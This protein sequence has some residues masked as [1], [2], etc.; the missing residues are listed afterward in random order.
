[1]A[2]VDSGSASPGDDCSVTCPFSKE[3]HV[4]RACGWLA[5]AALLLWSW[6]T[7]LTR[8][9][10]DA[11]DLSVCRTMNATVAWGVPVATLW[12]LTGIKAFDL[13]VKAGMLLL[14]AFGLRR[15][16]RA[17]IERAVSVVIVTF[18]AFILAVFVKQ[19]YAH[20]PR[21]SPSMVLSGIYSIKAFVPWSQAKELAPSTFPSDHA[22]TMLLICIIWWR[23]FGARVGV[24]LAAATF[25]V[26]L[27]RLAAGAHWLTDDLVGGVTVM[28]V[29]MSVV[30][31]TPFFFRLY[32]KIA[33]SAP[34]RGLV[35]WFRR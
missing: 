28:A 34:V 14:V 11:V 7:P 16:D 35:S 2:I 3:W 26:V 4:M 1:M 13:L 6:V 10:W 17:A 29:V 25:F 32:N 8:A 27:P 9:L 18:F 24:I 31:G 12:A 20:S 30:D 22:M 5:I 15:A 33:L 21:P 19:I 23:A